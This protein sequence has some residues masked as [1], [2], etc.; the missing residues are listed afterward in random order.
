MTN[1]ND[2]VI[3]ETTELVPANPR[4]QAIAMSLRINAERLV[5]RIENALPAVVEQQLYLQVGGDFRLQPESMSKLLREYLGNQQL[6]PADMVSRP[7][8][9][10]LVYNRFNDVADFLQQVFNLISKDLDIPVSM[11]NAAKLVIAY[12]EHAEEVVD[13]LIANSEYLKE[14]FKLKTSRTERI[15]SFGIAMLTEKVLPKMAKEGKP[16]PRTLTEYFEQESLTD[17]LLLMTADERDF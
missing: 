9:E 17:S 8:G 12:G 5:V 15:V 7:I 13:D 3:V 2:L 11:R 1:N 6:V 16:N 4:V 10:N 14:R